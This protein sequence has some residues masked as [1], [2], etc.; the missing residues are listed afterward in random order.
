MPE[1]TILPNR[2]TPTVL[3]MPESLYSE[4]TMKWSTQTAIPHK[5]H[6]PTLWLCSNWTT[7]V[8]KYGVL[9]ATSTWITACI[10]CL[11]FAC[12]WP[13]DTTTPAENVR[14]TSPWTA[15]RVTTQVATTTHK[16][17]R[18]TPTGFWPFTRTTIRISAQ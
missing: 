16:A 18:R 5:A 2:S 7:T 15:S 3:T 12:M 9:S 10:R 1:P 14:S 13:A 6:W 8:P 11:N 17:L 4:V